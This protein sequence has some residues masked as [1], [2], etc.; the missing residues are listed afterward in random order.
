VLLFGKRG[1]SVNSTTADDD[2][3]QSQDRAPTAEPQVAETG[4]PACLPPG[5]EPEPQP[6]ART[7]SENEETL[8]PVE[9]GP[10]TR[11]KNS[12]RMA[13]FLLY[14]FTLLLLIAI[15]AGGMYL[16]GRTLQQFAK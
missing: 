12:D 1:I 10:V 7:D 8:Q 4:D 2:H 16:V 14:V 6:A 13:F 9:Y 3:F 11:S 15:A 5:T